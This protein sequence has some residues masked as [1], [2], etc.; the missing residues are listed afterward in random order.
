MEATIIAHAWLTPANFS[1]ACDYNGLDYFD[2]LG[3]FRLL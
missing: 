2:P 1:T 3:A